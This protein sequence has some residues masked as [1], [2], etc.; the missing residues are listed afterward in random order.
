MR[1]GVCVSEKTQS[2]SGMVVGN[3]R[4]LLGPGHGEN[5][6]LPM[7]SAPAPS[8]LRV[9]AHHLKRPACLPAALPLSFPSMSIP[10][11]RHVRRR[12]RTWA[13]GVLRCMKEEA[14]ARE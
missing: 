14:D 12:D 7:S 8:L 9:N 6:L 3:G 4:F 10:G 11:G 1:T 5:H 2:E 13:R